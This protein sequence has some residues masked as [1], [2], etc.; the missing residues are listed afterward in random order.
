M[1]IVCKTVSIMYKNCFANRMLVKL[2]FDVVTIIL[3]S[4]EVIGVL[5]DGYKQMFRKDLEKEQHKHGNIFHGLSE[6][7][8]H[9]LVFERFYVD[10]EDL[11]KVYAQCGLLVKQGFLKFLLDT[12]QNKE[13]SHVKKA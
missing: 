8:V 4:G 5:L 11:N 12:K 3:M 10:Q 1:N 2:D 7:G 9:V 13:E 6:I